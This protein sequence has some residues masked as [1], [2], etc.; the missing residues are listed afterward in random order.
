MKYL[1]IATT[2]ALHQ[3]ADISWFDTSSGEPFYIVVVQFLQLQI[4]N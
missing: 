1:H 2:A 3:I 4:I